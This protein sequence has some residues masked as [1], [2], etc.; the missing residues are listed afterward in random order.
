MQSAAAIVHVSNIGE[1]GSL[2]EVVGQRL[3]KLRWQEAGGSLLNPDSSL[4]IGTLLNTWE[5]TN[6][7]SEPLYSPGSENITDKVMAVVE[8]TKILESDMT[9]R[10]VRFDGRVV[11]ITGAAAGHVLPV[12]PN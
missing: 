1:S 2:Y 12:E 5:H 3:R 9:G 7:F 6:D 11:L 10:E 8:K 4:S